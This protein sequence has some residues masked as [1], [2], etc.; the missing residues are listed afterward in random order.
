MAPITSDWVGT[1][2][3]ATF[4]LCLLPTNQAPVRRRIPG[5]VGYAALARQVVRPASAA[6]AH[7]ASLE[8]SR[9]PVRDGRRGIH[10]PGQPVH[11]V[12]QLPGRGRSPET[13]SRGPGRAGPV[14]PS[15]GNRPGPTTPPR[16]RTQLGRRPTCKGTS[17]VKRNHVDA[18]STASTAEML[19]SR[20]VYDDCRASR[21]DDHSVARAN[22]PQLD[23][24]PSR[25]ATAM[26]A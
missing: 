21:R 14:D 17:A 23:S 26:D 20:I 2:W 12:V 10:L 8:D 4:I 18:A 15:P 22:E 9:R 3:L 16:R 7:A 1:S 5:T 19:L 24:P 13:S 6:H 11:L 25:K